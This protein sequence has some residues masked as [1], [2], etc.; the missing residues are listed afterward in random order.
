MLGAYGWPGV[1]EVE[2]VADLRG[3]PSFAEERHRGSGI[4]V[5][6]K[7]SIGCKEIRGAKGSLA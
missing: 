7:Q 5:A 1:S 6:D 4:A 2:Q 3:S